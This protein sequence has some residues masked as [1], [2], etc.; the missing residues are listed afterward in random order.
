MPPARNVTPI[1]TP[2]LNVQVGNSFQM[3]HVWTA[4]LLALTL[5]DYSAL[6]VSY[7]A[8]LAKTLKLALRVM[9][10]LLLSELSALTDVLMDKSNRVINAS[11][12]ILLTVPSATLFQLTNASD[13]KIL[14]F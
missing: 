7:L 14:S 2:A 3:A 4:A 11:L 13:A 9:I 10:P 1:Q 5:M 6:T 12:V 8:K